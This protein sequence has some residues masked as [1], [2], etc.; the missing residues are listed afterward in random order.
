MRTSCPPA[1]KLNETPALQGTS[2][3]NQFP[4]QCELFKR[5][6][7]TV[8]GYGNLSSRVCPDLKEILHVSVSLSKINIFKHNTLSLKW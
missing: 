7:I 6:C 4:R 5:L 1:E 2:P 8:T 3:C